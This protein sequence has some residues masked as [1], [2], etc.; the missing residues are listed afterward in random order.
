MANRKPNKGSFSKENQP[1]RRGKAAKTKLWDAIRAESLL[2]CSEGDDNTT[3]EAR[4]LAHVVSRAV[5]PEDMASAQLLK[6]LMDKHYT[7]IKATL[8]EIEFEFDSGGTPSE[9]VMQ[10]MEATSTGQM[11]PDVAT[12]FIQAIKAAVDIEAAT[13]LK[14]RIEKLEEMLNAKG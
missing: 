2:G 5:D 7:S 3:V 12:M 4:F 8:P 1:K 11:P 14:E 6:T 10:I 9:Q 13:D